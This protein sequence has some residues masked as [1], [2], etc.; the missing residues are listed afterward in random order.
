MSGGVDEFDDVEEGVGGAGEQ[1]TASGVDPGQSDE[2]AGDEESAGMDD[3]AAA[4]KERRA[5]LLVDDTAFEVFAS[6]TKG[7]VRYDDSTQD[8]LRAVYRMNVGRSNHVYVEYYLDT[9]EYHICF[10]H[11][12]EAGPGVVGSR[13]R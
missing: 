7:W 3:D 9:W 10:F 5:S 2:G 13:Y 6:K 11:N 8:K 12:G 4:G 1:N